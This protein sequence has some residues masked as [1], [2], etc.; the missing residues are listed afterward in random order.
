MYPKHANWYVI[1]CKQHQE[2]RALENLERQGFSC[3]LPKLKVER[4]RL[5]TK[6]EA[7]EALF[8]SYLFINLDQVSDD[9]HPIRS[10]RGVVRIVRFNEYPIPIRG[11][12]IDVIR[13]RLAGEPARVPYLQPGE[14]VRITEGCFSDVEAIFVANDGN[15]R[16]VLLMSI[17]HHEQTLCFPVGMVRKSGAA[18]T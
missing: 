15:E 7:S 1:Q 9:W 10:T 2:S 17:L 11:E 3:Y 8:P 18:R 16:V 6:V 13:K 4:I 14:R 5:G 12:I